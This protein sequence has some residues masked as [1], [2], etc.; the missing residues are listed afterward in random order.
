MAGAVTN[1][2]RRDL[3][4]GIGILGIATI[5]RTESVASVELA[6]L[7][8]AIALPPLGKGHA[9]AHLQGSYAL[10]AGGTI[11]SNAKPTPR[12]LVVDLS[13]GV[14]VP[15]APMQTPRAYHALVRLPDGR[16]CRNCGFEPNATSNGRSLRSG[17]ECLVLHRASP[18]HQRRS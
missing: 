14:A 16:R 2:S 6:S 17:A 13:T 4:K 8:G 7:P 3:V 18:E 12:C 11:G 1:V 15:I 9:I 5:F 10:I